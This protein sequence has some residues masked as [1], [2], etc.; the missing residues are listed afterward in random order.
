VSAIEKVAGLTIANCAARIERSP[1]WK[2]SSKTIDFQRH[3]FWIC[4]SGS[5]AEARAAAP[6]MRAEWVEQTLRIQVKANCGDLN[7][8]LY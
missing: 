6:P 3:N 1:V 8:A 4:P 5:F 2:Y 7:A